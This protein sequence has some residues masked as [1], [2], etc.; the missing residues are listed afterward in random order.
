M[1][2]PLWMM[3]FAS[4]VIS[5]SALKVMAPVKPVA[6]QVRD[7]YIASERSTYDALIGRDVHREGELD[8]VIGVQ[9]GCDPYPRDILWSMRMDGAVFETIN[10]RPFVHH[11]VPTR[12]SQ[13]SLDDRIAFEYA[14]C[15][16]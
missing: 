11:I 15:P 6:H 9:Q 10:C 5:V 16:S 12:L 8:V 3:P 14:P 4:K 13:L 2:V 1:S 7:N